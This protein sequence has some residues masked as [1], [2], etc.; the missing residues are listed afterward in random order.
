MKVD[1]VIPCY[2][3]A[4]FLERCVASVLSQEVP[5]RVLIIDDAS[6]DD[7]AEVATRLS[8]RDERVHFVRHAVNQGHIKTYNE[9]LIGWA[10]SEYSLLLSA[11]DLLTPGALR[12]AVEV[13]DRHPDASMA[14]GMALSFVGDDAPP[15]VPASEEDNEY[16]IVRS[17]D[18]IRYCFR[19]GNGV[20]TP[21]A[22]VRTRI[23]QRV[24]GYKAVLRHSGDMEM[25]LRF[26]AQGTIAAVHAPQAFYRHHGQ[27]MSRQ[28]MEAAFS[29]A[30]ERLVAYLAFCDEHQGVLDQSL[31]TSLRREVANQS[32][33][34]A[35]RAMDMGKV[36]RADE[37]FS[38]AVANDADIIRSKVW[39]RAR[40]KR[41][42]G[43]SVWPVVRKALEACGLVQSDIEAIEGKKS[44]EVTSWRS[45]WWPQDA[46]ATL[47]VFEQAR[48]SP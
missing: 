28:Y 38:V 36:D 8:A 35:N 32:L 42:L 12:R 7:S 22:V 13:L 47:Q 39:K 18:F 21:T 23:Q 26:A 2:N 5:V 44:P 33:W 10:S 30:H 3:Y 37:A 16:R 31:L 11:D 27:N 6:K 14:Y 17:D 25:W 15:P 4:R 20:P 46:S 40:F 24:G 43:A 1:V 45:G 41:R 48:R 19:F 9:G 34:L 29:D